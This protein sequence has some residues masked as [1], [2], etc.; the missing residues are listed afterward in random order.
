MEDVSPTRGGRRS[1][2][3]GLKS[4]SLRGTGRVGRESSSMRLRPVTECRSGSDD[5]AVDSDCQ[6]GAAAMAAA[7]CVGELRAMKRPPSLSE[8]ASRA[9]RP[10]DFQNG[11]PYFTKSVCGCRKYIEDTLIRVHIAYISRACRTSPTYPYLKRASSREANKRTSPPRTLTAI[12]R[13]N[14]RYQTMC[15]LHRASSHACVSLC[16]C[17]LCASVPPIG[18]DP[19]AARWGTCGGC[20]CHCIL[21]R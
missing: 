13:L 8:T 14:T 20:A 4:C 7:M 2:R 17:V 9:A 18:C 6:R 21:M 10:Y 1:R 12:C 16:A 11:S 19:V 15:C 3:A 5:D